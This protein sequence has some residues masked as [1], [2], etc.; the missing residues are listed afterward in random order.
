M[1]CAQ[2]TSGD[3]S[4]TLQVVDSPRLFD[5]AATAWLLGQAVRY[6]NTADKEG[7]L[8][9][10]R[11]VEVLRRCA[12]MDLVETMNGLLRQVRSGDS[13]LRWCLLYVLGDAGDRGAADFLLHAALR[14]LPEAKDEPGCQS[15]RD[16]EILVATMAIHALRNVAGRHPGVAEHVLKIVSARPVRPLLV[17]AVKVAGELGL[18]DRLREILPKEDHWMLDIRKARIEEFFAEPE[19]QDGKERGFT[20]PR[21][22]SLYTAPHAGCCAAKER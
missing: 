4:D 2:Q 9:Y 7:E 20:P 18:K 10:A 19:R 5:R 11:I 14:P 15:D 6:L 13:S 22:G 16:M 1:P 8:A 3:G 21:S 12:S 17:E